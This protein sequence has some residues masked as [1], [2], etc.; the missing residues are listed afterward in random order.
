MQILFKKYL[1][2]NFL[3]FKRGVLLQKNLKK[4]QNF[5]YSI[6]FLFKI[7]KFINSR[8]LVNQKLHRNSVVY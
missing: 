1:I 2:N 7:L 8:V 5:I 6:N 4:K 3:E